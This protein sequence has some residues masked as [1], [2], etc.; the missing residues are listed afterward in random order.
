M[1]TRLVQRG[2]QTVA[3]RVEDKSK[4]ARKGDMTGVGVLRMEEQWHPVNGG[5]VGIGP[6]QSDDPGSSGGG[7][8]REG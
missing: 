5:V 2:A 3:Q 1:G 6:C 7:G 4:V 8:D